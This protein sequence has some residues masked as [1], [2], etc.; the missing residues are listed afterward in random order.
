MFYCGPWHKKT[1]S[2]ERAFVTPEGLE[3]PT[4]RT[5]ICYSIQLNY[6]A[7]FGGAKIMIFGQMRQEQPCRF[8]PVRAN[9]PGEPS[10]RTVRANH[11]GEPSG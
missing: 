10:G 5:G 8:S 9:H 3:P 1:H 6:G 11:P 4:D 7:I 2:L